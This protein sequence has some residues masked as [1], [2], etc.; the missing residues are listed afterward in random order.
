[1]ATI[2]TMEFASSDEDDENYEIEEGEDEEEEEEKD[3]E[4]E[5]DMI[6]ENEKSR[7]EETGAGT[8]TLDKITDIKK[9]KH[10]KKTKKKRKENNKNNIQ[11]ERNIKRS[12]VQSKIERAYEEINQEYEKLYKHKSLIRKN[13]FLLQFHKKYP[14][15]EKK[16]NTKNK[17]LEHLNK[18]SIH[19]NDEGN[20]LQ[21]QSIETT[22]EDLSIKEYKEKCRNLNNHNN[23]HDTVKK[24]LDSFYDN[25]TIQVENKYMYAGKTYVIKKKINKTSSSYK[26]YLRTKDKINLGGNFKDIDEIT[27]HIQGNTQINTVHKS[28]EDWK[29]YKMINSI[30]ESDLKSKHKFLED[31]MFAEN[32]ERKVYENKIRKKV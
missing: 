28:T 12:I 4:T 21:K 15:L 7:E 18:Y 30:N 29:N 11:I 20:D 5:N 19:C 22:N 14:Q 2:L 8:E 6:E 24:A 31:K 9:M 3:D 16:Y 23:V 32:V 25:N 27:E 13:D 17:L 10:I 1:M 26:R